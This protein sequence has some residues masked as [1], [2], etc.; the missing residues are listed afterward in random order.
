[1]NPLGP[2]MSATSGPTPA[3]VN[4][5]LIDP[6]DCLIFALGIGGA[7]VFE[8]LVLSRISRVPGQ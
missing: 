3:F 5:L 8:W 2:E 1:M 7:F 6:L 4:R